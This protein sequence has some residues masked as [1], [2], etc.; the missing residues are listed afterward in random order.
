M[1]GSRPSATVASCRATIALTDL[2]V[3]LIRSIAILLHPHDVLKLRFLSRSVLHLY[4]FQ[5]AAFASENLHNL[6]LPSPSH[7]L[8][9]N[10]RSPSPTATSSS[11]LSSTSS[12]PASPDSVDELS[13]SVGGPEVSLVPTVAL[14]WGRL[15]IHYMTAMIRLRNLT[16]STF[17]SFMAV[18][19]DG[20]WTIPSPLLPSL[21]H[22]RRAALTHQMTEMFH[23]ATGRIGEAM[24]A[25]LDSQTPSPAFDGS[26]AAFNTCESVPPTTIIS[27]GFD[28]EADDFFAIRWAVAIDNVHLVSTLLDRVGPFVFSPSSSWSPLLQHLF[29]HAVKAGSPKVVR[30]LLFTGRVDPTADDDLAIRD[31]CERGYPEVVLILLKFSNPRYPKVDPV[32]RSNYGM[33]MA[34]QNGHAEVVRILLGTGRVPPCALH[35]PASRGHAEIV[36]MLVDTGRIDPSN[37]VGGDGSALVEAAENGFAEVVDLILASGV[38]D[39]AAVNA[40][41]LSAALNGHLEVCKLLVF[42][43]KVTSAVM[44][45]LSSCLKRNKEFAD[46]LMPVLM[47][48][49]V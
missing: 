46:Q 45:E 19:V 14:D 21:A 47:G 16:S 24:I 37:A 36:G 12:S 15:G 35:W 2:P 10:S 27:A 13:L 7:S 4:V 22:G 6:I 38:A 40:A 41:L 1:S 29:R 20:V 39:G 43:R 44:P 42:T 26:E 32:S 9:K 33:R 11:T 30:F 18:P 17:S 25:I 28:L 49:V 34:S 48:Q 3:E 31:A 8:N 23:R 5:D